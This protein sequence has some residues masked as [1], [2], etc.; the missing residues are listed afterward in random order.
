MAIKKL[1]LCLVIIAL[2]VPILLQADDLACESYKLPELQR[3]CL[4]F[5]PDSI[6]VY[7]SVPD[8]QLSPLA[9]TWAQTPGLYVLPPDTYE[10]DSPLVIYKGQAILPHPSTPLPDHKRIRTVELVPS[11]E[12]SIDTSSEFTLLQLHNSGKAGGM[13][14]N[15]G[16]SVY[17]LQAFQKALDNSWPISLVS[18][19]F[20]SAAELSGSLLTEVGGNKLDQLILVKGKSETDGRIS[21]Q[22]NLLLGDK[23][24]VA[25]LA[26]LADKQ[27]LIMRNSLLSVPKA[28]SSGIRQVSGR[29]DIE[30]NDFLV[31]GYS[32]DNSNTAGIDMHNISSLAAAGNSFRNG[33]GIFV[34][35][36]GYNDHSR[37]ELMTNSFSPE[38]SP[39]KKG[40]YEDDSEALYIVTNSYA[41][42][43]WS[44]NPL[45]NP[46]V[47]F[48][49]TGLLGSIAV[50]VHQLAM[51]NN[52]G[53]HTNHT[54]HTRLNSSHDYSGLQIPVHFDNSSVTVYPP[55]KASRQGVPTWNCINQEGSPFS[56][57]GSY[58]AMAG[59]VL[60]FP[61]LPANFILSCL[62][63]HFC[64]RH[65]R[66][67]YRQMSSPA[68]T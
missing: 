61:G 25:V 32:S 62:I 27:T 26:Q 44:Q 11:S 38:I 22:R 40:Y 29:A 68:E 57:K 17:Q 66:S 60:I 55:Y 18:V 48:R 67:Q 13:E 4:Q 8:N 54:N 51:I 20:S 52:P 50:P 64:Y 39:F 34:E 47:F 58:A 28:K 49:Y 63:A 14:V 15:A 37:G 56:E 2:L 65:H 9:S 6:H 45:R 24:P 46:E 19:D 41:N 35:L 10:I 53:N 33:Q 5:S 31:N 59:F 1:L 23:V 30:H 21:F 3:I 16:S 42:A 36:T 43:L 12:F 7:S